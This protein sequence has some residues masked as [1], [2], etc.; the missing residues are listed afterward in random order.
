MRDCFRPALDPP[1]HALGLD[2]RV[3]RV[4]EQIMHAFNR[5][6]HD[7]TQN[8]LPLLLIALELDAPHCAA[9]H[10]MATN[11]YGG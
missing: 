5:L 7:R 8:R 10:L 1:K 4:G 6:E 2:P 11:L 3:N 9:C